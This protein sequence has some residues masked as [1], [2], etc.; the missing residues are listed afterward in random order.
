[1]SPSATTLVRGGATVVAALSLAMGLNAGATPD[2]A[3]EQLAVVLV[4]GRDDHGVAVTDEVPLH[5]GPDGRVVGV[6]HADTLVQVHEQRPPWLRVT[7]LEGDHRSGWVDDFSLRGTLHVVRPDAPACD[8]PTT[9]GTLL[10]SE[11]VRVVDVHTEPAGT[12]LG[13]VPVTRGGE[14]HLPRNW[15]RELPGPDAPAATDCTDVPDTA[16][17]DHGH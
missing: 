2:P 16:V 9:E 13:V 3:D 1:M 10:A 8:V 7:T 5:D 14:H 12:R 11:Q 6:L 15:V 4:S 17:P